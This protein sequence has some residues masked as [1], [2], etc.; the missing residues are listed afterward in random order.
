MSVREQ[1]EDTSDHDEKAMAPALAERF[2]HLWNEVAILH[3]KWIMW[4][5]LYGQTEAEIA[6]LNES[7]RFLFAILQRSWIA[8]LPRSTPS[9]TLG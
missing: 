2:D 7:A 4:K 8:S 1:P 6:V 9:P 5:Q 3:A